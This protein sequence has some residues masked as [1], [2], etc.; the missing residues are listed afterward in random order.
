MG[1][2]SGEGRAGY[3]GAM[4]TIR[5]GQGGLQ[6]RTDEG[7]VGYLS[8]EG[9]AG[10]SGGQIGLPEGRQGQGQGDGK[11]AYQGEGRVGCHAETVHQWKAT[12]TY[13]YIIILVI[14]TNSTNAFADVEHYGITT[15]GEGMTTIV[16][17]S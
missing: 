14:T 8:G 15:M 3:S 1:Y 11:V 6:W 7:H 5:G 9:R 13:E 10:Y 12:I 16:G 4:W 17:E 2:L